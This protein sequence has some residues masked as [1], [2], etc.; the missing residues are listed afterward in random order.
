MAA[1]TSWLSIEKTVKTI[2]QMWL[3]L[4]KHF[5]IVN[6]NLFKTFHLIDMYNDS[7]NLVYITYLAAVLGQVQ[8]VNLD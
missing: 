8:K 7:K 2:L 4:K 6:D 1:T 3:E 5:N